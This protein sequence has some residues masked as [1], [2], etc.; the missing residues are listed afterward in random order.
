MS[1]VLRVVSAGTTLDDAGRA[2]PT[3]VI[4]V[5]E[6]PVLAAVAAVLA[7]DGMGDLITA[8]AVAL[9]DQGR[10][11]VVVTVTATRPVAVE[12]S[13]GF[14][15]P[16]FARLLGEAAEAGCLVLACAIGE[17]PEMV[18]DRWLGV[19]LDGAA[20]AELLNWAE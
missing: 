4:D 17:P 7:V 13:V 9:D 11:S 10:R 6:H 20:L 14:P 12:F 8:A 16:G 18:G 5:S 1:P 15:L 19:D 3:V 2:F